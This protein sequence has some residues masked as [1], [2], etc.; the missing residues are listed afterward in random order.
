M[1]L[2]MRRIVIAILV[3][4]ACLSLAGCAHS[5]QVAYAKPVPWRL[6]DPTKASGMKPPQQHVSRSSKPTKVSSV[7]MPSPPS[8]KVPNPIKVS[9]LKP[10]P[11][12]LR[13]PSQAQSP[14]PS[15]PNAS[16]PPHGTA[17]EVRHDADDRFKAA[18]AKAKLSGVHTLTQKDIDGLSLEQIKQLRG[19]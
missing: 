16:V 10:S 4:G 1:W 19:Y 7:K 15:S 17:D 6:P 8:R 5:N 13:K 3:L 9:S 18:Q 2:S 14:I 12:P 11:L